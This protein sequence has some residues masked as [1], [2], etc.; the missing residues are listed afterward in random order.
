MLRMGSHAGALCASSV[1]QCLELALAVE[2]RQVISRIR[3]LLLPVLDPT[4]AIAEA[5]EGQAFVR[6]NQAKGEGSS[7]RSLR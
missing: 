2:T 6:V 1:K 7:F 4:G 3:T 5:Q